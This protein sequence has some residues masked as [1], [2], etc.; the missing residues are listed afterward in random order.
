MTSPPRDAEQRARAIEMLADEMKR[1]WIEIYRDRETGKPPSEESWLERARNAPASLRAIQ[2]ALSPMG[3]VR[4]A[5]EVAAFGLSEMIRLADM[6]LEESL[7]EPEERGN[8]ATY[9][10]AVECLTTVRATLAR[11]NSSPSSEG[12]NEFVDAIAKAAIASR[13]QQLD[14]YSKREEDLALALNLALEWLIRREPGDSRAVSNEFVA[15]AAIEAGLTDEACRQVIRDALA[16]KA[17]GE[18]G[19]VSGREG[20]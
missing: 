10:R 9:N 12:E 18:T 2:R 16:R 14:L 5:L 7:K 19:N 8:Y 11:L 13:D 4:E 17:L 20:R 15:M 3:D 6:G 1:E